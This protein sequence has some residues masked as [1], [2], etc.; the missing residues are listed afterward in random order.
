MRYAMADGTGSILILIEPLGYLAHHL[1]LHHLHLR[2][3]T[4]VMVVGVA[5]FLGLFSTHYYSN[6]K[7]PSFDATERAKNPKEMEREMS[8]VYGLHKVP[9][10][11]LWSALCRILKADIIVMLIV[12]TKPRTVG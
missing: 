9:A 12:R 5:S 7:K 4:G 6:K 8:I 1:R 3:L 2:L 11:H 10:I